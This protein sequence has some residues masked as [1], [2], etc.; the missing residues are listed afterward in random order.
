MW[1][2]RKGWGWSKQCGCDGC[3]GLCTSLPGQ[4]GL[5]HASFQ[6]DSVQ[7]CLGRPMMWHDVQAVLMHQE[8]KQEHSLQVFGLSA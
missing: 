3:H 2:V 4:G 7:C 5:V 6:E 8:A 1:V